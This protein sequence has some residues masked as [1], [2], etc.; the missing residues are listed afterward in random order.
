MEPAKLKEILTQH[1]KW[2]DSDGDTGRR[3]DLS[4]VDLSGADLREAD[5]SE[6]DLREAHLEGAHLEGAHLEGAHLEGAHLE[7]A[8]L[9][10][11]Y[12]EEAVLRNTCIYTFTL[13]K[14]IGWFHENPVYP[15]G[16]ILQIGCKK[17][18]FRE[19]IFNSAHIAGTA[20]YTLREEQRYT[21]MILLLQEWYNSKQKRMEMEME[22]E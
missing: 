4:G 6:A 14:D 11:A 10:G 20:G 21:D 13:G 19:A 7:G 9:R 2:T 22:N 5:L 8:D 3:A 12:L 15:E 1:K 16:Y 17:L 18:T